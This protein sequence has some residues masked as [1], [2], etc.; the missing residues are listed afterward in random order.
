MA[1]MR[2]DFLRQ[3]LAEKI[4]P[5]VVVNDANSAFARQ[6]R[7]RVPVR[8]QAIE[9][10]QE[11]DAS[12]TIEGFGDA[13]KLKFFKWIRHVP[14]EGQD[15]G[16]G[17]LRCRREQPRAILDQTLIGRVGPIPFKKS[18][19]GM[20]QLPPL[21]VSERMGEGKNSFLS[22][23]KQFL[24]ANSGEEVNKAGFRLLFHPAFPSK[25]R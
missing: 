21:A 24:A 18:E 8:R 5:A 14:R 1:K 6:S 22:S 15:V 2:L 7:Q 20:V 13:Q 9:R 16:A 3:H 11:I 17:G 10:R 19:F 12:V 23:R 25:K 4:R